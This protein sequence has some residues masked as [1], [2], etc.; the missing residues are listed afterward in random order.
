MYEVG[1]AWAWYE[2]SSKNIKASLAPQYSCLKNLS[3]DISIASGGEHDDYTPISFSHFE[4][5][6]N[7]KVAAVSLGGHRAFHPSPCILLQSFPPTLKSIH[8]TCFGDEGMNSKLPDAF[9]EVLQR[10]DELLPVLRALIVEGSFHENA[11][12]L[13]KAKELTQLAREKCVD[14]TII[15]QEY[16]RKFGGDF[17]RCWGIDGAVHWPGNHCNNRVAEMVVLE[18]GVGCNEN[19]IAEC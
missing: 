8:L 6:E 4:V 3:L 17:D 19:S 13:N 14:T 9:L 16:R 1:H 5:L 18:V 12:R 2:S 15:S 7:L 10:K 11:E